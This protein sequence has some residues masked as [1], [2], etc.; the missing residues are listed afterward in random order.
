MTRTVERRD[1]AG[2]VLETTQHVIDDPPDV[3]LDAS[4]AVLDDLT[5]LHPSAIAMTKELLGGDFG[6]SRS[7]NS[8]GTVLKLPRLRVVVA[9]A[10]KARNGHPPDLSGDFVF[11]FDAHVDVTAG[12][13]D[14]QIEHQESLL[15]AQGEDAAELQQD[16]GASDLEQGPT[17]PAVLG[18]DRL[19]AYDRATAAVEA[20]EEAWTDELT[21]KILRMCDDAG[22]AD[23]GVVLR[24]RALADARAAAS[25]RTVLTSEDLEWALR[26]RA[27][28]YAALTGR[29]IAL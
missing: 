4:I 21:A 3:P 1:V 13:L 2:T 12:A 11:R 6:G 20:P 25:G 26:S 24:L 15:F 5:R 29:E 9:I 17:G 19:A 18:R 10:F 7:M 16:H 27:G 8:H 23:Q 14:A 22:W 28:A